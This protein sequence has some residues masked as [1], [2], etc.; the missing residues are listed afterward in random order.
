MIHVHKWLARFVYLDYDGRP[1][2]IKYKICTS[3]RKVLL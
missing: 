2:N 1:L 3:C